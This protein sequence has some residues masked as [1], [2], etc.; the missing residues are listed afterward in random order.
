MSPTALAAAARAHPGRDFRAAARVP[1]R[2]AGQH[3]RDAPRR[4]TR[5]GACRCTRSTAK[6]GSRPPRCCADSTCWSSTCRTSASRIYTYIYTM[7]NCLM[8]GP[9]AR[10]QGYRLR[11]ARIRSAASRSKGLMLVPGY[12][13]FVGQYPIPMRHGMTIGELA[14]LFNDHFG[15]GA[16]SRG[17]ADGRAGAASMYFDDDR[18]A[19]GHAVAEHPDARHRRSS[20]RARCCSK[21]R[22]SR[23]GAA[24]RGRSSSS[25]RRG[26]IAERFAEAMNGRGLPG[27]RFRPARLRADVPEARQQTLRRLPDS[28]HSIA[29]RS[30]RW[31]PA[32]RCIAAFRAADP[33]R[34][35]W[36]D[37]PYEYEH[38][39]MPID[40]LA[41]S[42]EL[43]EQID[44]GRAGRR[45][46]RDRGSRP[47]ARVSEDLREQVP[48][49]R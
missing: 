26:S 33:D 48:A 36:R 35:S 42:S 38:D 24:R 43:R 34:F 40:I 5:S 1:V 49:V 2:R 20:I 14:R 30:A 7:A 13:S 17:R 21:A 18:A 39:K 37:P 4:R 23:K 29:R 47:L 41:G 12:E 22:T 46:S 25:A 44:A 45:T 3:D 31:T 32:S 19:V 9:R 8:R 16:R 27:V 6:R 28:R 11:P 15:I 10:R